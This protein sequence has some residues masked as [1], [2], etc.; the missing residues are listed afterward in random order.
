MKEFLKSILASAIGTFIAGI[1]AG[2][3]LLVLVVALI[4]SA[5]MHVEKSPIT[6][7]SKTVLVIGNGVAINDTPSH[8]SPTLERL[9]GNDH[10]V[11]VDLW[12]AVES[13][14]LAAKDSNVV[15]ILIA[16][17]IQAGYVQLDELRC[18]LQAYKKSGKPLIAWLENASQREYYLASVADKIYQHP[19]GEVEFKGLETYNFYFGETLKKIGVGVQVTKVGKYKSAVEPYLGDKMSEPSREQTEAVLRG[20][21]NK[22]TSEVA[23]SRGLSVNTLNRYANSAGIFSAN[24]ALKLHLVDALIQRDE[25]IEQMHK[26]GA[27]SNESETSFRQ[28]SLSNYSSKAKL[29]NKGGR[30]AVVYAEGEIVDG[31]GSG[32][33]V[34]GDE[35]AHDLRSLRGDDKLKAVVLRINSPGG[36]AFASDLVARE[37]GLLRAKGIPVIVSMGD[38]AASGGY[39]IAAPANLVVA[40]TMTITGSIGVFGLHF[41]YSELANKLQLA[42]DGLKTSR[43]SDLL[44]SH[45]PATP[46]ELNIIQSLVDNVYDDFLK[47]VSTGRKM[48]KE[49][50]HE[51]AQGRVWLGGDAAGIGLVDRIGG[52]HDS[53][54]IAR[55]MAKL[56]EAEIIQIPSLYSGRENIIQRLISE[57]QSD[58]PLFARVSTKNPAVAIIKA[59][60]D[61]LKK[62]QTLN[63]P[64]GIYLTCP[65]QLK[66]R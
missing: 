59:H 41:N 29:P 48:K 5:G 25:L 35:L 42:T 60:L 65:L 21:W 45:R 40:D 22:I 17:E 56:D 23:S 47:V 20:V 15:G 31:W 63:D 44:N 37:V 19:A 3:A 1:L 53:I 49:D 38:V 33:E 10:V 43:Y 8:G 61:M 30:I 52:L 62:A 50:I 46:E 27:K 6:I 26:I 39:Y 64:K 32:D 34:G 16:G 2:F 51:I 11:E 66:T 58:Q 54:Q 28:V 57:D 4:S 14:K 7:K 36:S 24:E 18:A 9:L 13:I 55:E 12:R